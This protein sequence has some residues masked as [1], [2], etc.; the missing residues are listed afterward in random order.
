M[1]IGVGGRYAQ[2]VAVLLLRKVVFEVHVQRR[3]ARE[4][5]DITAAVE[6]ELVDHVQRF[7]L[8]DIEIGVVT[9]ARYDVAVLAIPF[10][11]FHAHVLGRDGPLSTA[12]GKPHKSR[13]FC[14]L[15]A[16]IPG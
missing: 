12:P 9:V 13:L 7:V 4:V 2:Q 6:P 14:P 11:V 15:N 3:T 5:V 8:D 16:N 10:G 1:K